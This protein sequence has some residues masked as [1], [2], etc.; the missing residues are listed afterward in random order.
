MNVIRTL[1]VA[2]AIS[3][4]VALAQSPSPSSR[5]LVRSMGPMPVAPQAESAKV[6]PAPASMW[7]AREMSASR[8]IDSKRNEVSKAAPAREGDF[9]KRELIGAARVLGASA[10]RIT[11]ESLTWHPLADGSRAARIRINVE[12][13]TSARLAYRLEGNVEPQSVR[14]AGTKHDTIESA[15]ASRD[16]S[17]PS[18]TDIFDGDHVLIDMRLAAGE[19]T[20]GRAISIE[21]A[22]G[23][24]VKSDLSQEV[25]KREQD[26]G[27]SAS[28]MRDLACVQNPSQAL[29][30]VARS[31]AKLV[32]Q[33]LD[34]NT[35]RCSATLVAN[36]QQKPILATATHC[37]SDQR[38]ANSVVSFWQ[39]EAATCGSLAVPTFQRITDGARLLFAD[40]RIDSAFAEM[41]S[42]P[43]S[44]ALLAGWSAEQARRGVVV[45]TLHHP[46]GDLKKYTSGT[47]VGYTNVESV[48]GADNPTVRLPGDQTTSFYTAL[49]DQGSTQGG[50]SGAGIFTLEPSNSSICP[51]G[52]YL[53]RGALAQ[54]SASCTNPSGTDKYSRFDLAFPYVANTFA[55]AEVPFAMDGTIATEYY[56]VTNDHYFLTADP[57]EA[58]NLDSPATRLSGW[59]RTGEQMGVWPAGTPGRAP[60]CR[61]FGDLPIGGPNSHFYTADAGECGAV[62]ARNSGWAKESADAFRVALPIGTSCPGGTSPLY[63]TYNYHNTPTYRNTLTG[64]LGYDSNHR[65]FQRTSLFDVMLE[66]DSWGLEPVGRVPVMCVR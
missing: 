43:P 38:E 65:Y 59:F 27:T 63:R 57:A 33:G 60:V 44:S 47:A 42:S 15:R 17:L 52:C 49:W 34:G 24:D 51:G 54:G 66:K 31:T 41:Y 35:Y 20:S 16:A 10:Q 39:F 25:S 9:T 50:S 56:N 12:G 40:A 13:A 8:S 61:F 18:W 30:D 7:L 58:N 45:T 6:A 29:R 26:I 64:R 11:F 62:G 46:L 36:A 14:F 37:L 23:L 22:V 2:L 28:C 19:S 48:L 3:A 1:S 32:F 21:Q 4:G 5:P 55:P 53:F